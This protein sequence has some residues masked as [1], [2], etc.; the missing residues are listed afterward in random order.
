MWKEAVYRHMP[1]GTEDRQQNPQ[2]G[3]SPVRN[4]D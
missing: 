4:F 1:G 3:W 2:D